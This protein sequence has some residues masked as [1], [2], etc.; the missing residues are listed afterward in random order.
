MSQHLLVG[1]RVVD[2][3]GLPVEGANVFAFFYHPR[4]RDNARYGK[5]DTNG[6]CVA[7]GISSMDMRFEIS[8][9]GYY[10]SEG[11]YEFPGH[12]EP[13]V[14]DGKWQPWRTELAVLFR[15]RMAPVAMYAK[16]VDLQ[17]PLTNTTV[18]FDCLRGD[19]VF[20][21]GSGERSD[22]LFEYRNDFTDAWNFDKSMRIFCSNQSDGLRL[23][24]SV[25]CGSEFRSVYESAGD[26][27]G[28]EVDLELKRT[29]NTILKRNELEDSQYITFRVRSSRG[30]NGQ[31]VGGMYG[32]IY[33]P[34]KY[35]LGPRHHYLTFTYYLNPTPGD[36]NLEFD[37]KQNLFKD[38]KPSEQVWEP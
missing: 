7:T 33:G 30:P 35:G 4:G 24:D 16:R 19:L 9:E 32:K 37:P 22:M 1:F 34:L 14:V 21:Y 25:P 12:A 23:V 5:T 3:D 15:R 38:L 13:S 10:A 26:E 36:R 20:P 6:V 2:D 28:G 18:G 17:I 31:V 29:T 27:W 8:K 11:K